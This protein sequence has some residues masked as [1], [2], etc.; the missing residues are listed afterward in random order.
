MPMAGIV[1]DAKA[2]ASNFPQIKGKAGVNQWNNGS[3]VFD[4]HFECGNLL[5]VFKGE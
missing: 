1:I 2:K 5:Y 4:S 3:L